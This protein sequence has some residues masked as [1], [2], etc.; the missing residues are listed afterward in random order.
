MEQQTTLT[1]FS[2]QTSAL[3]SRYLDAILGFLK[4]DILE[5]TKSCPFTIALITYFFLG[6]RFALTIFF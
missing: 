2:I 3:Q 5:K 1:L 4:P 6:P